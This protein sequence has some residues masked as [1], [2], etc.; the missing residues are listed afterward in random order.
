MSKTNKQPQEVLFQYLDTNGDGTGVKNA[1]GDYSLAEEEF[2][3]TPPIASP[4]VAYSLTRMIISIEDSSGMQQNEY[5]NLGS[6]LGAGIEVQVLDSDNNVINNM[7]DGVP[8]TTNAGWGRQCYD[9]EL[10]SW[11]TAPANE[12]ILVRWTFNQTGSPILL[13]NG[14]RL[15]VV[16]NDDLNGLIS[17]YYQ[18]QGLCVNRGGGQRTWE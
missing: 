13:T 5:G 4:E 7:T 17:H 18:V 6:A 9:V 8:V 14:Q 15:A 2:F 3:I 10:K 1:N 16:F 11:Q 12:L